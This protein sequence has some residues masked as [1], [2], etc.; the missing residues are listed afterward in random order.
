MFMQNKII[1]ICI[2]NTYIK[3]EFYLRDTYHHCS[4]NSYKFA[5][6]KT[7]I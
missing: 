2:K 6:L 1:E 7:N 5:I 4:L 3:Q